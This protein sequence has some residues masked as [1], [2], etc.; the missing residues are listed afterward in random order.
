M[1]RHQKRQR[2][3][4]IVFATVAATCGVRSFPSFAAH[5]KSTDLTAITGAY[6]PRESKGELSGVARKV[7]AG[8]FPY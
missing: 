7:A 3:V 6:Q 8:V 5:T 1:T 2:N 4:R